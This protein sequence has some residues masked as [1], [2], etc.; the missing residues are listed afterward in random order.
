[1]RTKDTN[2]SVGFLMLCPNS[3]C[4][5]EGPA[6]KLRKGS[7][8]EA[9]FLCLIFLPLGVLYLIFRYGYDYYCP[10]CGMQ[11]G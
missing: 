6:Q 5:Y 1:M 9:T 10:K 2:K 3:N 11:M 8:L 4:K 7:I